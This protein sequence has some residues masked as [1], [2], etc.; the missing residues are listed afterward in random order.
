MSVDSKLIASSVTSPA[1]DA[2][3]ATGDVDV[4]ARDAHL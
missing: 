3:P 4:S 2:A 1:G